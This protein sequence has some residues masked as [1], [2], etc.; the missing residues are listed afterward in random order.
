MMDDRELKCPICNHEL[1]V[2]TSDESNTCPF[3]GQKLNPKEPIKN[4]LKNKNTLFG[5]F[6]KINRD[7]IVSVFVAIIIAFFVLEM[8]GIIYAIIN[9]IDFILSLGPIC[10]AVIFCGICILIIYLLVFIIYLVTDG[11]SCYLEKL[12]KIQK[13]PITKEELVKMGCVSREDVL[14]YLIFYRY[15]DHKRSLS[16]KKEQESFSYSSLPKELIDQLYGTISC[17]EFNDESL[18][19]SRDWYYQSTKEAYMLYRP[20]ISS[21]LLTEYDACYNKY[22]T[23]K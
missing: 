20:G 16:G 5:T 19:K 6:Y 12:K 4:E 1:Q 17:F 13:L 23:N 14:V 21:K 22:L 3:Y 7:K 15:W 8:C 10:T 9:S 18:E 2:N 11:I